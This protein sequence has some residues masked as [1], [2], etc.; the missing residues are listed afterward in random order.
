MADITSRLRLVVDS[1][2]VDKAGRKLKNLRRDA[3]GADRAVRGLAS[4][5][6]AVS[7]A[8]GLREITRAIDEYRSFQNQLRIITGSTKEFESAQRGL[9]AVAKDSFQELGG[10]VSIYR[11]LERGSRNL[12]LSQQDLVDITQTVSRAVAASGASASAAT[13]AI[14]Q[15][16]Q[17]L[18]G[19]FKSAGQEINSIL[20][21]TPELAEAIARGLGIQSAQLKRLA[22]DQ[23]LSASE[24]ISALQSQKN[25]VDATFNEQERTISQALTRLGVSVKVQLG[26]T[27]S[28]AQT[29]AA[30]SI[31]FIADNLDKIVP[32]VEGLAAALAVIA[33]PPAL[34]LLAGALTALVSPI[35]LVIAGITAL[36]AFRDDIAKWAF[37]VDDAGAVVRAAFEKIAPAIQGFVNAA[38]PYLM[39]FLDFVVHTF[40]FAVLA[41]EGA[42]NKFEEAQNKLETSQLT[43]QYEQLAKRQSEL[44]KELAKVKDLTPLD[45][46]F[47]SRSLGADASNAADAV[48]TQLDEV[49]EEI[50]KV[51]KRLNGVLNNETDTGIFDD[52]IARAKE[53][54]V[55]NEQAAEAADK[56]KRGYDGAADAVSNLAKEAKQAE[57]ALRLEGFIGQQLAPFNNI[58]LQSLSGAGRSRA[59]EQFAFAVDDLEQLLSDAQAIGLISPQ[60]LEDLQNGLKQSGQQFADD[61]ERA[62]QQAAFELQRTFALILDDLIF[63]AASIGDIFREGIR[64]A[65]RGSFIEPIAKFLSGNSE[66]GFFEGIVA[67]F[68]NMIEKFSEA[69]S[70]LTKGL[71]DSLSK[72]AGK[73]GGALGGALAGFGLGQAG[74]DLLGLGQGSTGRRTLT[75]AATGA[76][77]GFAVGGPIGAAVGAIVGA[78]SGAISGLLGN[79]TAFTSVDLA[80]GDITRAQRSKKDSRNSVVSQ[81]FEQFLPAVDAIRDAL[82][83]SFRDGISIGISENGNRIRAFVEDSFNPGKI[84]A[85]GVDR[86]SGDIEA[87]IRD[88]LKLS[89]GNAFEGGDALLT[90]LTLQLL[91]AQAPLETIVGTLNTFTNFLKIGEPPLSQYAAQVQ[92]LNRSYSEAISTVNGLTEAEALLT[93]ALDKAIE[94]LRG[95][96]LAGLQEIE[97]AASGDLRAGFRAVAQGNEQ[98][99]QDELALFGTT[100]QSLAARTANFAQF[101]TDAL[102]AGASITEL[103]GLFDSFASIATEAGASIEALTAG[104]EKATGI[105]RDT[106]NARTAD[107]IAGFLDG[108][109]DQLEK[110]LKD[111]KKRIEEAESLGADLSQ[112]ERLT[113]LELRDFFEGLS[114]SAI[115]EV[116]DFLGLFEEAADSVARNLDLSR[117]DLRSRADTFGRFAEQFAGLATDFRERF[118]A[119][120]PRESIDILRGRTNELLG[121]IGQGNESAAQALPQVINQLVDSA[122]QSFGNTKAFQEVLDFALNALAQAEESSLG[123]QS[124]AERQIAALDES[125][126]LLADIRD[127]L[128]SGQAFNA[129]LGSA[130]SGGVASSQQLLDLIQ[131]GAGLTPASANDNAAALSIT[132]LIAQSISPVITPLVSSIDRFTGT[133]SA[134]PD[135]QRLQIEATDRGANSIVNALEDISN[136]LDRMEVIEKQELAELERINRAA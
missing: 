62:A 116:Q 96:L 122:R 83:A 35:G 8:I 105:G 22:K 131:S 88:A 70:K 27:F 63:G 61:V 59:F 23:L 80:S 30:Q 110:L 84:I 82:G 44:V 103:S 46:D 81:A 90:D 119:A 51:S 94:N 87:A 33:V 101:F 14:I 17:A 125:N 65:V 115:A 123:V 66:Q 48:R 11:G 47:L 54:A 60:Q 124:E 52:I 132:S 136:R 104:L 76:S 15:F 85:V 4:A 72:I 29:A 2:G 102:E 10:V 58:D 135:L 75:G 130:S 24:V 79:T 25:A 98:L 74:A 13:G 26:E 100:T 41:V 68:D 128:Q 127:I 49:N 89:I 57:Q 5:F 18:A 86:A 133:L 118:V 7:S 108:P 92:D 71:S 34:G 43:R 111:Q 3:G 53:L 31:I 21:Q 56:I 113:A 20:E 39:G 64:S 112:V 28:A 50:A 9:I 55:E 78:L 117:Q 91:D 42:V 126:D 106:F 114:D 99:I 134:M 120:S 73:I 93:A 37:G 40:R 67:S 77:V 121:Q 12:A 107:E 129:I 36:V 6:A 1:T 109:L 45:S 69:F 19:D 38:K 95:E 32:L 97:F 16:G